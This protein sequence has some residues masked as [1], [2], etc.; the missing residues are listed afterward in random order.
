MTS[1]AQS[2]DLPIVVAMKNAF[3]YWK[4]HKEEI[5]DFSFKDWC[6]DRWGFYW[7]GDPGRGTF[8][9]YID[10]QQKYTE[11]MLVWQ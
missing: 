7:S 6:R 4:L 1:M 2:V 10:N 5:A 9:F 8:E 11:F 3:E